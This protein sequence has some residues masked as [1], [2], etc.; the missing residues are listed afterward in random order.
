[1]EDFIKSLPKI[2]LHAHLNGSL[3]NSTLKK[4][5]DLKKESQEDF[6]ISSYNSFDNNDDLSK[7]FEKF[8][9]AHELVD[10]PQAVSLALQCVIDEFSKENVIYLEIRSTPRKTEFMSKIEYLEAIVE[11]IM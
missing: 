4:L 9:L 3:S 5:I 11:Q 1:M 10:T 7:C 6:D 2:E 8:K